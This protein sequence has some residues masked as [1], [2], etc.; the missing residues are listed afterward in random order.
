MGDANGTL[1]VAIFKGSDANSN[2]ADD[3]CLQGGSIGYLDHLA[4][5]V[6]CRKKH[7]V[8][9]NWVAVRTACQKTNVASWTTLMR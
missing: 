5:S 3:R 2:Y 9:R 4:G 6:A 1:C 7:D 8:N